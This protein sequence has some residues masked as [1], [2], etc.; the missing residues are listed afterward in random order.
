MIRTIT[1]PLKAATPEALS[2]YGTLIEAGADGTPFGDAD[3]R[4]ELGR[5]TPRLYI[6]RLTHRPP[7]I[8]AITRHRAVTQ[9][10]AAMK[11]AAWF[12]GLAASIDPD[13]AA[14]EP[15]PAAIE[16]FQIP[17][18]KALALRRG[19]WHA[20]PYFADPVVDFLNLE[21]SDTNVV[22]HH[23]VQIDRRF[24]VVIEFATPA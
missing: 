16:V 6:M 22:D 15:D 18:D 9:C 21:L 23:T 13:D 20:G 14:E 7:R 2:R 17:G 4:L 1:L 8:A 19:T 5:G 24:G 12:I 11:G 10:L 3:A